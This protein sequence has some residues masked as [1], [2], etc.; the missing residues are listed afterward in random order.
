MPTS[1]ARPLPDEYHPENRPCP[2][3]KAAVPVKL[4]LNAPV[5]AFTVP[6]LW[7]V[8]V[9]ADVAVAALP[10]MLMPHVPLAFAP[11]V[12]GAPTVL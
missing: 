7:F 11:P 10:E 9:V 6:P 8:A 12:L 3:N 1:T 4:P 5:V 2:E